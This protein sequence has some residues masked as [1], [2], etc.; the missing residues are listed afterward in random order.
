MRASADGIA[1]DDEL[2][3][4]VCRAADSTRADGRS[5]RARRP[6]IDGAGDPRHRSGPPRDG[7]DLA[8]IDTPVRAK[9]RC[10]HDARQ[11]LEHSGEPRIQRLDLVDQVI[12]PQR[13]IGGIHRHVREAFGAERSRER[14]PGEQVQML[15][16]LEH[17]PSRSHQESKKVPRVGRAD[18]ED[19]SGL[20]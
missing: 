3:A 19:A 4:Q 1:V 14:T 18:H 5:D 17:R 12:D 8:D 9:H 2:V 11:R 20:Q 13:L 15:H 7:E 16:R 6:H 10:G